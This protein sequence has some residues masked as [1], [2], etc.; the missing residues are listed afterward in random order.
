MNWNEFMERH[1]R[2]SGATLRSRIY[3][4]KDVGSNEEVIAMVREMPEEKYKMQLIRKALKLGN[5]FSECEMEALSATLSA[6]AFNEVF[7]GE[8][9]EIKRE[10]PK[11]IKAVDEVCKSEPDKCGAHSKPKKRLFTKRNKVMD[12]LA[13]L[14][15]LP[16][17]AKTHT[18]ICGCPYDCD[19][20]PKKIN[21]A[22]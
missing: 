8:E 4:L 11:V 20:C 21:S 7:F 19:E 15:G 14:F 3:A 13:S 12:A 16:V 18:H 6:S 5:I 22:K 10:E 17:P 2:W 1:D 9:A